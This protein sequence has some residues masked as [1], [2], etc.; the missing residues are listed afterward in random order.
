MNLKR[1]FGKNESLLDYYHQTIRWIQKNT[2]PGEG[3]AISKKIQKPYEEVTGYII[4]P[5]L[6][7][8]H[9]DIAEKYLKWLISVQCL[10][11][12]FNGSD[13]TPSFF[14][15]GQVL[16]GFLAMH[17]YYQYRGNMA[18]VMN[19]NTVM[20]RALFWMA[21]QIESDGSIRIP[22]RDV[23]RYAP[24]EI[25]PEQ[26]MLYALEPMRRAALMLGRS[27]ILPKIDHSII[28]YTH[29]IP[30]TLSHYQAYIEDALIDLG[31]PELSRESPIPKYNC[32]PGTYQSVIIAAKL[33]FPTHLKWI[34]LTGGDA[35]Y[36]PDDELSWSAK[37]FLDAL[38]CHM[39]SAFKPDKN[40]PDTISKHDARYRAIHDTV[41]GPFIL[42]AG[43]GTGRY[44]ARLKEDHPDTNILCM[45]ISMVMVTRCRDRGFSST[46]GSLM[47]LPHLSGRFNTTYCVEALEHCVNKTAA[48]SELCRVTA[49]DGSVVIIDKDELTSV[50]MAL[51]PW[52]EW[53]E[54]SAVIHEMEKH[55]SSVTEN[56]LD[57]IFTCWV[58]VKK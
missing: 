54:S 16:R 57:N 20:T 1:L 18:M 48:I 43:A 40:H 12:S 39:R 28:H 23:F 2:I 37:F 58:G 41:N 50:K 26:I 15:T 53:P 46:R 14:D 49:P 27:A 45:D 6:E 42:D 3:I 21:D 56:Q 5:L 25:A 11:G 33:G 51:A 55:C 35:R 13:G 9:H 29:P 4:P 24:G 32:I 38:D 10:N 30:A 36:F 34:G 17:D 47:N 7:F 52:E 44:A 8:G 22:N 19:C 31:S